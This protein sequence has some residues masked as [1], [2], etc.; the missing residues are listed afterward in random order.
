MLNSDLCKYIYTWGWGLY[1]SYER[2]L[3]RPR[4]HSILF[5]QETLSLIN[6]VLMIEPV[7]G[8]SSL[9][10]LRNSKYFPIPFFCNMDIYPSA[11]GCLETFRDL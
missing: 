2:S 6:G 1:G 5:S 7:A 3:S 11:P 4:T 9:V 10:L 8:G